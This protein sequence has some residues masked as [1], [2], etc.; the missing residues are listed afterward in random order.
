MHARAPSSRGH[1]RGDVVPIAVAFGGEQQQPSASQQQQSRTA[2]KGW[3]DEQP[4]ST[5]TAEPGGFTRASAQHSRSASPSSSSTSETGGRS[6][7]TEQ[8]GPDSKGDNSGNASGS[9][10]ATAS[11]VMK[12]ALEWINQ[13]VLK[14]WEPD[15]TPPW[16]AWPDYD[17]VENINIL[18]QG[19]WPHLAPAVTELL[20][21]QVST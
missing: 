6:S 11:A 7:G 12:Q 10:K 8:A 1:Q 4:L 2:G 13:H 20:L 19:L 14:R 17:R 16:A 15:L 9:T 5:A 18:L 3:S 21:E